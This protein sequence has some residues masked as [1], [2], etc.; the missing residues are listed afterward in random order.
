MLW[1]VHALRSRVR[2]LVPPSSSS[3]SPNL[4]LCV[5]LWL[6]MWIHTHTQ[7]SLPNKVPNTRIE[8]GFNKRVS[9]Y[10]KGGR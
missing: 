8:P 6:G 9:Q 1:Q 3:S 10:P 4:R 7:M 5:S 2:A